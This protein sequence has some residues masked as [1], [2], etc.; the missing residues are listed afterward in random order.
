MSSVGKRCGYLATHHPAQANRHN[1]S[2][3][4][5]VL[6][7]IDAP[8]ICRASYLTEALIYASGRAHDNPQ[9]S[10]A[11][12]RPLFNC[13]HCEWENTAQTRFSWWE[14]DIFWPTIQRH[15]ERPI[16][17][18]VVLKEEVILLNLC[19]WEWIEDRD[20]ELWRVRTCFRQVI[21]LAVKC[22]DYLFAVN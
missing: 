2:H 18:V 22:I 17:Y 8:A 19:R 6:W 11:E 4:N 20:D 15:S 13:P 3:S 16:R 12:S 7:H 10:Y 9:I 1:R 14:I 21:T 5:A